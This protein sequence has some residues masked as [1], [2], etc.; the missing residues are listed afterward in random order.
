MYL[1]T[2]CLQWLYFAGFYCLTNSTTNRPSGIENYTDPDSCICPASDVGGVCPVG[3]FCPR[4]TGRPNPCTGG[5]YC[6]TEG[7]VVQ[8]CWF[9]ALK[10]WKERREKLNIKRKQ[11]VRTMFC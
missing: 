2:I 5:Y 1:I 4:G 3:F 9:D 10:L 6:D 8:F 11:F 7:I